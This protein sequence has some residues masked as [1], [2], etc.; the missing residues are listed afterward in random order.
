VL[1][2]FTGTTDFDLA[3]PL[4]YDVDVAAHKYL[5]ALEEG[6]VPLLLLFSGQ[7]FTGPPT[8]GAG[9]IAVE[10]VPWHKEAQARLPVAAWREAMDV[11][12]PDQA[13]L[14]V[15]RPTWDRLAEYRSRHGL[16]GWDEALARLL[17]G[18]GE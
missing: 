17:D 15:A 9:A 1:P 16:T 13:W 6:D 18:A 2:S 3:L 14:R 11:H 5:A 10:P 12:F 8:G 4:S 7:V